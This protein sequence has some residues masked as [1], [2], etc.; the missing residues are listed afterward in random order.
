MLRL[1]FLCG[2]GVRG[3]WQ[4]VPGLPQE[5]FV[6]VASGRLV[7]RAS[8]TYTF[9]STPTNPSVPNPDQNHPI[10]AQFFSTTLIPHIPLRLYVGSPA[11]RAAGG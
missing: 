10:H 1:T 5:N 9:C 4:S 11:N 8:G 6:Q 2:D 3:L 7:V